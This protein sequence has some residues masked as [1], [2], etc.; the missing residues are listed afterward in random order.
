MAIKAIIIGGGA[1]G[2]SAAARARR[3]SQ[4]A[5][6]RLFEAGSMITHA[7]CGIPYYVGGVVGDASMLKTYSPSEFGKRRNIDVHVNAR[8]TK[9]DVID[10]EIR[11]L[12]GGSENTYE[13]DRLIIATGA[14][15]SVPRMEGVGLK[16]VY[17]VR[18][19]DGAPEI[20][21]GLEGASNVAVVGGGYIGLEMTEAVRRSGKRVL[22]F[23]ALEHVLPTTFD[24]DVA[25]IL[26]EELRANGVELHLSEPVLRIEGRDRVERVITE[27]GSYPIDA[28]V[29]AIGVKPDVD[30]AIE[31]GARIGETG[32][33][34]VNEYMETSVPDVYA[35]GDVAETRDMLTDKRA[36]IPLAPP[37]NKMGQVAG[38]NSVSPRSLKFP[39]VLGTAVTKV[40]GYYAARTGLVDSQALHEGYTIESRPIKTRSTAEYY[41]E[42]ETI[43]IKL[44]VEKDTGR[45][46]G[47]QMVSRDKIVAGY[48]DLIAAFVTF[49]A[50]IDD[51]FFSDLSYSPLTSPVWHPV[52]TAARVLSHGR[53]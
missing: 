2:A 12:E 30:L 3:W 51:I 24:D 49:N 32:A 23:E 14:K 21:M 45:L 1:A 34:H 42:G 5:D 8:V 37:A 44:T 19:P 22:L 53:F 50:R 39:G 16:G 31:A 33:V 11:V 13:W 40:F 15:P 25:G 35:A 46:L 36:W 41:P 17:T 47:G 9:V 6:I 48:I 18:I 29:L 20:K 7:P 10:K 28:V 52:I 43:H 26:H 4:D 38:A 27:K